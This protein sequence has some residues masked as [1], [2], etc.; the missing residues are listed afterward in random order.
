MKP[1][2]L[3]FTAL[4]LASCTS[5]T[6]LSDIENLSCP[7]TGFL[8]DYDRAAFTVN[9]VTYNAAMTDVRGTCLFPSEQ[10]VSIKSAFT[11]AVKATQRPSDKAFVKVPYIISVLDP[12]ENIIANRH[13]SAD[14]KVAENGIGASLEEFKQILPVGDIKNT[15]EYKVIYAFPKGE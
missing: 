8:P 12:D 7:Q 15:G 9:G 14:V 13:F 1:I 10:S 2:Y 6:G 11:V 5:V 4:L 3:I